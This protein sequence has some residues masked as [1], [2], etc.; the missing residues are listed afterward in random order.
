LKIHETGVIITVVNGLTTCPVSL[1][2]QKK[3]ANPLTVASCGTN[4]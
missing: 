3:K 1:L 4:Q 2:F